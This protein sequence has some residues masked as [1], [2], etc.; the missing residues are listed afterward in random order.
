M[1][2]L[3]MGLLLGAGSFAHC[4]G[5]CGP[6]AL[7]LSQGP[8][9]L[10]MIGRQ[11]AWHGGRVFTYVFLGALCGYAGG[12]LGGLVA[13]PWAM[14]VLAWAAGAVMVI[15]GL[16][17]MGV[18]PFRRPQ[19]E[20]LLGLLFGRLLARPGASGAFV[21]GLLTGFL[22]CG[23]VYAA[24][25]M[26]VQSGSVLLG[27]GT[28][29]CAGLGSAWALLLLAVGGSQLRRLRGRWALYVAGAVLIIAGL[30]VGVRGSTLP[31]RVLPHGSVA[32]TTSSNPTEVSPCCV[33]STSQPVNQSTSR[34]E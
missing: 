23:V 24:L 11:V 29:A 6:I 8:A 1:N 19:G 32:P 34:P 33:H 20:G 22:P 31:C 21:M 26:S 15:A 7:H 25:A 9:R 17:L 4:L 14:Q 13:R 2:Y 27:M 5:M 3:W 10:A 12:L 28:M 16:R 18:L 30:A